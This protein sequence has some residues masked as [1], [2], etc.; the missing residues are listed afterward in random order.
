M[1]D[2][3]ETK[4]ILIG[5]SKSGVG[6]T[7][8][9]AALI[10]A[11][12]RTAAIKCSIDS[13]YDPAE[14]VGSDDPSIRE[15]GKDTAQLWSAGARPVVWVKATRQN[16]GDVFPQVLEKVGHPTRLLIEGNI[17]LEHV[18]PTLVIF[19]QGALG[20]LKPSAQPC[21]LR[22]DVVISG[23]D[24]FQVEWVDHP[25]RLGANLAR[26]EEADKVARFLVKEYRL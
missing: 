11:L 18:R 17:A 26:E 1:E 10:K 12:G 7:T 9:A 19:L 6:K 22:A 8:L 20:E 3:S 25:L 23:A 4:V 24:S 14:V 5:G 16:F 21:R 13:G 2:L 15:P